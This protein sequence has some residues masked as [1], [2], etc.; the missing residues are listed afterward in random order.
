MIRLGAHLLVLCHFLAV[1]AAADGAERTWTD[2]K[3]RKIVASMVSATRKEVVVRRKSD[4]KTFK[5]P[6]A[7][8]SKND[9]FFV[10]V[11]VEEHGEGAVKAPSGNKDPKPD[12]NSIK[13][14]QWPHKVFPAANA[15]VTTVME[16]RK[17]KKF[18]YRTSHF[19]ITSEFAL[20]DSLRDNLGLLLETGRKYVKSMPLI[21]HPPLAEA[22][23]RRNEVFLYDVRSRYEEAGGV[24][25][26]RGTVI[27]VE[28]S[29]RLLLYVE[30]AD[31]RALSGSGVYKLSHF[32]RTI[33][34][35]L[36]HQM[37]TP[38]RNLAEPES[39]WM[40]GF[41]NY[42]GK[43]PFTKK[44]FDDKNLLKEIIPFVTGDHPRTNDGC[45]MGKKPTVPDLEAFLLAGRNNQDLFRVYGL[46][47]MLSYYFIRVDGDGDRAALGA[48]L[49]AR[50]ERR[51]AE[52]QLSALLN[53]RTWD[54]LE[55]EVA[56]FWKKQ[57]ID[58]QFQ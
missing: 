2:V 50:R 17:S 29:N 45:R 42:V 8:L 22:E 57:G 44:G 25:K 3:G 46:G 35:E 48:Y 47:L 20:T 38:Q 12:A 51:S 56:R 34:H 21:L 15:S 16:D 31:E 1:P 27:A 49:Q 14:N 18:A 24:P 10:E 53:G 40:E 28:G 32:R 7:R 55:R 41:A 54:E 33:L 52:D 19:E 37:D 13:S 23:G 5:I 9:Q 11:W 4:G 39:W 30:A 43:T 58:I 6:L 36:A 26:T